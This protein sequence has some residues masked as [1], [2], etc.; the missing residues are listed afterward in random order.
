MQ[1][2]SR[3][4][5]E[6]AARVLSDMANRM[7]CAHH[8]RNRSFQSLRRVAAA[9]VGTP[10]GY[11]APPP[12]SGS[13]CMPEGSK[14]RVQQGDIATIAFVAVGGPAPGVPSPSKTVRRYVTVP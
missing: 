12:K 3:T 13:L 4:A 11:V 10:G 5:P 9:G 2:I 6:A 14:R 8:S 1:V 7:V